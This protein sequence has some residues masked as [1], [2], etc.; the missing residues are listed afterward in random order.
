MTDQKKEQKH[1]DLKEFFEDAPPCGFVPLRDSQCIQ[2]YISLPQISAYCKDERCQGGRFFS[3]DESSFYF[4]SGS[5]KSV[6]YSCNNCKSFGKMISFIIVQNED[7][8]FSGYKFGE[9]P[10]FGPHIPSRL[11]KLVGGDKEILL[12]ESRC[13]N[14][15]LGVGAFAYYRRVVENQKNKIIEE[16]IKV[17]QKIKADPAMIKTLEDAKQVS[18]FSRALGM[19]KDAIPPAL[20]IDGHHNPLSLLHNALSGG[21]HG[22]T[23]EE[24]LD[25]AH[26]VR[27]VLT[28]LAE[29][30]D[31]ALKD[32]A[33]LTKA[34]SRLMKPNQAVSVKT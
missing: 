30:I 3:P 33:E 18:E 12:K 27:L 32:R 28:E 15:G 9:L 21:L 24:C 6:K 23:D 17:A 25:L 2:S 20:L 22:K 34:V 31:Q 14:Q 4:S 26:N 1:F 11:L 10:P 13:E 29:R 8:G 7:S 5:N 16:I 19:I